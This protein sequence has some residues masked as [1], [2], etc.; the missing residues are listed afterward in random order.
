VAKTTLLRLCRTLFWGLNKAS[1][2]L[3]L[4]GVRGELKGLG[5]IYT[6]LC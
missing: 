1:P 6:G 4:E 2:L 5:G 3:F